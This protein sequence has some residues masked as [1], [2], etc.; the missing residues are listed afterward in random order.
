VSLQARIEHGFDA[1]RLDA[2]LEVDSGGVTALFGPSGAG[3]TTLINA[4][5]GLLEPRAGRIDLHGRCLFDAARGIW[6]APHRRRIGYV[7]QDARLFPHLSV[8]ANLL[9]GWRRASQRL[10]Q[11]AVD[12]LVELLGIGALL[13]RAPRTLSGGERQ[14]VALGRALLAAPELLLLDEPLAAV[15]QGRKHEILPYLE[16]V[17]DE[18]RIPILYVSHAIDEVVRLAD[19][20]VVL[21]HGRIVAAG[22]TAELM[23]RVD[24]P[25]LAG[26]FDASAVVPGQIAATDPA[27]GLST[28]RFAGGELLV[29]AFEAAPGAAVRLRI[30]ARSVMI[31]LDR[32][33]RISANN[34]LP[35]RIGAIRTDATPYAD[36]QLYCG[37][38]PLLAR[39][40][41][42]SVERLGLREGMEV[43]A[44][45]KAITLESHTAAIAPIV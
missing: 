39:I 18:A 34:V 17:R 11:P 6:T 28:V 10:E 5:A 37:P 36:V 38:T 12:H 20:M 19:R 40:T 1:F 29:P 24:L 31:A 45:I 30:R 22:P 42:H 7:F 9:F 32:P 21:E 35:A 14:R 43:W 44:I 27:T 3:K 8:R 23:A 25:A 41:R 33:G 13:A 26:R 4:L 2:Q 16:R 15:D